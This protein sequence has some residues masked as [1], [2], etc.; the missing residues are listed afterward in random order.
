MRTWTIEEKHAMQFL[1]VQ[2][3][4][5]ALL[6]FHCFSCC[7]QIMCQADIDV[8]LP[9]T[10]TLALTRGSAPLCYVAHL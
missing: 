3:D 4:L 2:L 10:L 1:G 7:V 9:M 8:N 5:F 6:A